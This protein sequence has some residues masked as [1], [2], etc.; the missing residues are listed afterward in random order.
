MGVE[1]AVE[2]VQKAPD[3][4]KKRPVHTLGELLGD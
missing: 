2:V 1:K 3:R 4:Y